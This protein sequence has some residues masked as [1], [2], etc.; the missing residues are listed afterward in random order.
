MSLKHALCLQIVFAPLRM[1][2]NWVGPTTMA[3]IQT[4]AIDPTAHAINN[5]MVTC[6]IPLVASITSALAATAAITSVFAHQTPEKVLR[7]VSTTAGL[8]LGAC[9][10]ALAHSNCK[11]SATA[12]MKG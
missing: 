6:T 10:L 4:F 11:C 12:E 5:H 3:Y 1:L 8:I 7:F 9:S 2:Y